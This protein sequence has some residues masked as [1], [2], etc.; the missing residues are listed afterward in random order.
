MVNICSTKN[1]TIFPVGRAILHSH[2]QCV[3]VSV[4]S[5]PH[6]HLVLSVILA[7]LIGIW[8]NLF[9]ALICISLMTN[10]VEQFFTYL[11][12]LLFGE[13]YFQIFC[14]FLKCDYYYSY[15]VLTILFYILHMTIVQHMTYKYFPQSIALL[16][17]LLK[18]FFTRVKVLN[19]D[20][21]QFVVFLV[22]VMPWSYI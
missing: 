10:Y 17:I 1:K 22:W 21:I 15:W 8:W 4:A 7:I 3:R 2:C 16:L 12:A 5:Y 20:E 11:F 14:L 19:L 6:Q 9:L 13:A 18:I